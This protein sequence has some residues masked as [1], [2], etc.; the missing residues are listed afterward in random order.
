MKVTVTSIDSRTGLVS[1]DEIEVPRTPGWIVMRALA[2]KDDPNLDSERFKVMHWSQLE[3]GRAVFTAR[4]DT[5][6][7]VFC[8]FVDW[9][10][11]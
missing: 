2:L 8:G 11:Q 6:G 4:S 10:G 1:I 9:R 5:D 3:A 7:T